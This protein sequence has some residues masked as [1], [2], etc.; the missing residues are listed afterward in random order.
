MWC[1]DIL[2][3]ILDICGMSTFNWHGGLGLLISTLLALWHNAEHVI[4]HPL[5]LLLYLVCFATS[6][7]YSWNLTFAVVA[8]LL[9]YLLILQLVRLLLEQLHV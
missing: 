9:R 3:A 5:W 7:T 4:S 8:W 6:A 1:R 2:W